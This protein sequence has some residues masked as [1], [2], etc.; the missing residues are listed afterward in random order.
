MLRFFFCPYMLIFILVIPFLAYAQE[1]MLAFPEAEGYGRFAKGGR[2]GQVIEVTNLNDSGPGSLRAALTAAGPRTV[3]F[4]VGGTITLTSRILIKEL[5]LTVAGQTAPG[6]GILVRGSYVSIRA[7]DVVIRYLRFRSGVS[8]EEN[9][10]LIDTLSVER[11]SNGPTVSNVVIDHCS[12]SW[13]EDEVI[14]IWGGNEF[15]VTNITYQWSII[16]EGLQ[17]SRAPGRGVLLGGGATNVTIH[18]SLLMSN[19]DRNPNISSGHVD[20]VNNFVYNPGLGSSS[21]WPNTGNFWINFENNYYEKGP[22]SHPVRPNVSVWGDPINGPI[23]SIYF[24]GNIYTLTRP[25]LQEPESK[26]YEFRNPDTPDSTTP[27]IATTRFSSSAMPIISSAVQAKADVLAHAGAN[28]QVRADG[29]FQTEMW[30]AVDQRYFAEI[31]AGAGIGEP[32]SSPADV[33]GYP[34]IEIGPAP[35]DTD[36]DGMPDIWELAYDLNPENDSD[37]ALDSNGNGYTN[38]EEYLNG[39]EP[40]QDTEAPQPPSNLRI[41]LQ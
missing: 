37:G 39:T 2:G 18:H 12:M 4:R 36:H 17:T 15:N 27:T 1:P 28:K 34:T 29:T 20:F 13:G 8:G 40:T 30:D 31:N 11:N 33:G 32:I 35:Q 9:P 23:S 41:T 14:N 19:D 24:S 38:L 7:S 5:F 25:T 10:E 16:S 26:F 22:W 3:V 6:G 21:L